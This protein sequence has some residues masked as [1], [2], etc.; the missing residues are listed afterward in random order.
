MEV[1]GEGKS[2]SKVNEMGEVPL[3]N[4]IGTDPCSITEV[5]LSEMIRNQQILFFRD[6]V[7]KSLNE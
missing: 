5:W 7:S 4:Q 3:S 1:K 2:G 6:N